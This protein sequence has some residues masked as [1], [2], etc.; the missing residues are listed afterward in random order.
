MTVAVH[1]LSGRRLEDFGLHPGAVGRVIRR[2]RV[3]VRGWETATAVFT[4]GVE[5]VLTARDHFDEMTV[6]PKPA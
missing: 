6:D 1:A 2:A 4:N 5:L 3:G